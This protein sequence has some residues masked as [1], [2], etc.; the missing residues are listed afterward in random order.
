MEK[1][2][3]NPWAWQ[4]NFGFSQAIEF[5]GHERVLVCAGQTSVDGDGAAVHA[6]DMAAQIGQALNNLEAVLK[7]ADMTL[8]NVVRLNVY[9]TDVNAILPAWSAWSDRLGA[10]DCRPACTLLGVATLF[11]PEIMVELE[12][13][14]VA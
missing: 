11:E 2:S 5:K 7:K 1:R 12:A 10:A 9:T 3:V 13:T 14:A 4:D 8:K 6:G